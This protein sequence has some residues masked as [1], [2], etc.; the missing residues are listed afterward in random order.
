[1]AYTFAT[2]TSAGNAAGDALALGLP[3]STVNGDLLIAAVYWEGDSQ[4]ISPPVG[5]TSFAASNPQ[6][7]TGPTPDF[8]LIT[9]WKWARGEPASWTWTPS[10]TGQ[11]RIGIVARYTPSTAGTPDPSDQQAGNVGNAIN[12]TASSITPSGANESVLDFMANFS[13]SAWSRSSGTVTTQRVALGGLELWDFTKASSSATGTTVYSAGTV[14]FAWER[15]AFVDNPER[16][17]A[18]YLS[19]LT[20]PRLLP[21][22]PYRG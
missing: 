10:S 11:F 1:M 22:Q 17:P 9:Y 19:S 14:Q 6:L 8:R 20:A 3:L 5:W 21:M 16:W 2:S 15:R 13:G 7:N 12:F 4:T 18:G